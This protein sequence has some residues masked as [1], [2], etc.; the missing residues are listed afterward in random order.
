V[1]SVDDDFTDRPFLLKVLRAGTHFFE[2]ATR[3]DVACE[4]VYLGLQLV[5]DTDRDA[6]VADALRELLEDRDTLVEN[7]ADVEPE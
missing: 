4:L 1:P 2:T 5:P 6:V 3:H 7:D